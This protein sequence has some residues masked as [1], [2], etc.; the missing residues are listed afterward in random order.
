MP[1]SYVNGFGG[2]ITFNSNTIDVET[3][4]LNI[5]AEALDTTNTGDAGWES[6]ILGAKSFAG[7]CKVF[8]E[9]AN[10]ALFIAGTRASINF[11]VSVT[12]KTYAGTVQLTKVGIE[13]GAKG[14]VAYNCDFKGSGAL[15]YNS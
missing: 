12:G 7:S 13:N 3:W 4:G 8:G 11:P 14:V 15:T 9:A 1:H 10:A 6:N 2:S 5:N